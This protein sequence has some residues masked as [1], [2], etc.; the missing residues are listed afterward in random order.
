MTD[1]VPTDL[2][3]EVR[4]KIAN[5]GDAEAAAQPICGGYSTI[6]FDYPKVDVVRVVAS[7]G[8][9]IAMCGPGA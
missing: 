6:A 8:T 1:V 3:L 7:D 9:R 2:W 4:T 5:D